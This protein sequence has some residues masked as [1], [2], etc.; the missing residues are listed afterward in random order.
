MNLMKKIKTQRGIPSQGFTLTELLVALVITGITSSFVVALLATVM[1]AERDYS[2][3]ALAFQ[4]MN[5]VMDLISDEIRSALVFSTAPDCPTVAPDCIPVLQLPLGD[6]DVDPDDA[7]FYYMVEDGD[8]T[9]IERFGPP[10]RD[11]SRD[12]QNF[13]TSEPYA[14]LNDVA[15]YQA[16]RVWGTLPTSPEVNCLGGGGT[17]AFNICV[18]DRIA[19]LRLRSEDGTEVSTQTASRVLGENNIVEDPA[20]ETE[21]IPE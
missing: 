3:R 13:Y 9:F 1:R 18:R 2:T 15:A 5:R 20:D 6:L 11:N 10:F 19:I 17:E 8:R 16:A 21:T 14:N 12:A 4:D 7:I